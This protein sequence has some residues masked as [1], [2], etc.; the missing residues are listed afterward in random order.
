VVPL[1][2]A[3]MA[4]AFDHF[5]HRAALA[6]TEFGLFWVV[7]PFRD[8]LEMW[9][10]PS[11][12]FFLSPEVVIFPDIPRDPVQFPL[13]IIFDLANKAIKLLDDGEFLL[14]NI[15]NL[16]LNP[17]NL[18]QIGPNPSPALSG[19]LQHLPPLPPQAI[20]QID[21]D[22]VQLADQ[23]EVPVRVDLDI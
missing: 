18:L 21:L 14:D 4:I 19:P 13:S 7:E 16:C 8:V 2:F 9:F 20:D 5:A 23:P 1:P 15:P 6:M 3:E 10:F 17:P 22:E 11:L 12:H